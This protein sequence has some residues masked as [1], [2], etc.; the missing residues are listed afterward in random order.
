MNLMDIDERIRKSEFMRNHI[1]ECRIC[2]EEVRRVKE[3]FAQVEQGLPRINLDHNFQESFRAELD[4][5]FNDVLFPEG[6]QL[7]M[8]TFNWLNASKRA[9]KD[10]GNVVISKRVA[11]FCVFLVFAT[12]IIHTF[13]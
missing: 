8:K 7:K 2:E 3:I 6:N 10:L 13:R 1:S 11:G 4:E 5:S 12:A 9:F